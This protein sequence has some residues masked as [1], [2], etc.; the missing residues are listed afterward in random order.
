L[1]ATYPEWPLS[2]SARYEFA[3]VRLGAKLN[4]SRART[5]PPIQRP[6]RSRDPSH[7]SD[8]LHYFLELSD[9][10]EFK[11]VSDFVERTAVD[12]RTIRSWLAQDNPPRL[13][14]QKS[15]H[16]LAEYFREK[17]K[18]PE[19]PP[20][21]LQLPFDEFK[22]Q[23]DKLML[24]DHDSFSLP[25]ESTKLHESIW[26]RLTGTYRLYRAS[27]QPK[28]QFLSEILVVEHQRGQSSNVASAKILSP[29]TLSSNVIGGAALNEFN[30]VLI[31]VGEVF[32]IF[33]TSSDPFGT[34][35]TMVTLAFPRTKLVT[36]L[37]HGLRTSHSPYF[38]E[39]VATYVITQKISDSVNVTDAMKKGIRVF[40]ESSDAERE[41]RILLENRSEHSHVMMLTDNHNPA[42][43][44]LRHQA[45][46]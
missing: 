38:G 26:R 12:P 34:P 29:K 46:D 37:S 3:E 23:I 41:I 5:A 35:E 40:E 27:T 2:S 6:N 28:D 43:L 11:F 25:F 36:D 22:K 1:Y 16:L 31:S 13:P 45:D 20:R 42:L 24:D 8:K 15:L 18:L 33:A 14:N 44:R 7:L 17:L 30:G 19:M 4:N 21:T 39:I 32:Y 10:S 9:L